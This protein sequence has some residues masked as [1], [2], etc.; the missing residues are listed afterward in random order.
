[1]IKETST[2]YAI[3]QTYR[4]LTAKYP[5]KDQINLLVKLYENELQKFN[6]NPKRKEGWLNIGLYKID[7][8]LDLNKV[9]AYSVVANTILNSDACL[10]KR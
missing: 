9:A 3:I 10:T 1:M 5:N 4:K 7:K 8:N 2:P 6:S